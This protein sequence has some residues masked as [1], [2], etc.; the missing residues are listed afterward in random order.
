MKLSKSAN[1]RIDYHKTHSEKNTARS[2]QAIIEQFF[3]EF[4]DGPFYE[5][6]PELILIFLNR[7]NKRNK[8]T[9]T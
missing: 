3:H 8:P 9:Y 5:V 4:G 7:L 6:V 1:I 2:Y